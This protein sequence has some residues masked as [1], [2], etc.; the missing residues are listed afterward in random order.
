MANIS[1]HES[2]CAPAPVEFDRPG[3][4]RKL[5]LR[6]RILR[7]GIR[8]VCGTSK[9]L[10]DIEPA[11]A[12][13]IPLVSAGLR[14]LWLRILQRAGV[15]NVVA[16]SAFGHRF[17]CHIGDYAEFPYYHRKAL[18]PE[19]A[20]CAAWLQGEREPVI[21]DVGANVGFFSTQLCQILASSDPQIYAFEPVPGTFA[22]L[23]HSVQRL[24]LDRSV[25]PVAAA[26]LTDVGMAGITSPHLNSLMSQ[27]VQPDASGRIAGRTDHVPAISL[28]VFRSKIAKAPNLIK[29]DVEGCEATALRGAANIIRGDRPPAIALEFSPQMLAEC[30][31]SAESLRGLLSDY[32]FHYVDDLAGQKRDFGSIVNPLRDVTWT[33]NLFAVPNSEDSTARCAAAF[34]SAR[35]ALDAQR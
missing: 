25:H 31:E 18:A 28:D 6:D 32:A 12:A 8:K 5:P 14:F 26:V 1:L 22:K 2:D 24:E 16:R 10:A 4:V 21:Y 15:A 23:V 3:P 30:G 33:C 34:E 29:I 13:D 27:V 20:L 35:R 17:V 9:A 7:F 19:L 11:V